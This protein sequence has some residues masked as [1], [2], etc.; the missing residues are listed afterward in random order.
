MTRVIM[1]CA[2]VAVLCGLAVTEQVC[3]HNVYA[4]MGRDTAELIRLVEASPDPK[5]TDGHF[6]QYIV[7]RANEL[8]RYW[9]K[10]EKHMTILI[11]HIDLSYISDALIYAT[12]F[13]EFDNKEEALAGLKRLEY[14]IET[15]S[16]VYG[17]NGINIL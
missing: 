14:L 6:D 8:G 15:Y 13:I 17:L 16:G 2:L 12:N 11:K 5:E 9:S 3:I 1:V 10:Q 7:E 4:K